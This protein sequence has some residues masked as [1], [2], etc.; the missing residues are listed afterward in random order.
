M[1][2]PGEGDRI[3]RLAVEFRPCGEDD[4]RTAL[5]CAGHGLAV[6]IESNDTIAAALKCLRNV[7]RAAAHF[8]HPRFALKMLRQK[9][10]S[11]GGRN[12]DRFNDRYL[13]LVPIS[14]RYCAM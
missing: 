14:R 6:C 8:D 1:Q 12:V 3:D 9:A 11:L 5:L 13:D 7:A 10:D 2:R 4:V